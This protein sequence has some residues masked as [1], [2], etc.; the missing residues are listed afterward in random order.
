MKKLLTVACLLLA[1][2]FMFSQ[3]I[4]G[5]WQGT[6]YNDSTKTSLP[7]ELFIKKEKG[8]F[9]GYSYT[10]FSIGDEEYYGVKKVKVT[11]AKDGKIVIKD[12]ELVENNYP[13]PA[14][15]KVMQLNILD[16]VN[17]DNE[18]IMDGMFVTNLTKKY[19]EITG[20]INVKRISTLTESSLMQYL[21]KKDKKME[22]ATTK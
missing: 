18:N 19:G 20:H 2:I 8:K 13:V 7:Y 21:E 10:W 16:L 3:D 17:N 6:M 1:P 11:I 5:L 22:V 15:K 14:D 4:V 9:N 12:D